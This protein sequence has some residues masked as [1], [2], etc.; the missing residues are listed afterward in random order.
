MPS[1]TA[2]LRLRP[3]WLLP[4]LS[5]MSGCVTAS[6][7]PVATDS[8]C[9]IARPIGYDSGKDSAETVAEIE[10]HNSKWVCVCE[11]DCPAAVKASET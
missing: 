3:L 9:A 4:T 5:A 2:L 6:T 7:G 10:A 1:K 8:Y 11:Q